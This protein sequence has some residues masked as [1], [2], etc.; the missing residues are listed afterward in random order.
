MLV[1]LNVSDTLG[2]GYSLQKLTKK[3]GNERGQA[4]SRLAA[5]LR[6]GNETPDDDESLI[7]KAVADGITASV[8]AE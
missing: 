5:G 6:E 7:L 8:V 4:L 1:E 2:N 3:Y